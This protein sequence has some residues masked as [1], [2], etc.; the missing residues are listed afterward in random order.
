MIVVLKKNNVLPSLSVKEF[1]K[2]VNIYYE[3][4]QVG[5]FF[6]AQP[7]VSNSTFKPNT[8]RRRPHDAAV[9]LSRVG[10]VY[11]IRN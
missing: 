6:M 2:S 9:E 11:E 7:A 4:M 10:G 5:S 3:V 1:W 8:H